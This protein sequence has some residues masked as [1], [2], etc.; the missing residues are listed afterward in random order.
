[1]CLFL[2]ID[3]RLAAQESDLEFLDF[4]GANGIPFVLLFTKTDKLTEQILEKN[5]KNYKLVLE[6][7]WSE[8]PQIFLTSAETGQGKEKILSFIEKTNIL[9]K[10]NSQEK[11]S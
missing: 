5:L 4:L 11:I 3:S 10:N 8:L 1:M 9:W 7:S 2:L 6:K